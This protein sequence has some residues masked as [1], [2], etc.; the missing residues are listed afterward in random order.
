V[1]FALSL[2]SPRKLA[3][4]VHPTNPKVHLLG[5]GQ[6]GRVVQLCTSGRGDL[7]AT[8]DDTPGKPV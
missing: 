7:V 6:V 3:T 1:R 5:H 8:L 2:F 4:R